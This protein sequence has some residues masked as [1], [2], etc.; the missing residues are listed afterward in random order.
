M[1]LFKSAPKSLCVLRLS[2]IGDVCHAI[3]VVQAIQKHWPK[4]E[5]TWICGKIEAQLIGDL[6]DIRVI[7]FDKKQGLK[8]MKAVWKQLSSTQ[9][10]VLLHMQAALRASALSFGIK[11]K[12]KVGFSKNRTKEGQ[13]LFTNKHLPESESFHVLDNFADFAR[14]IGVPFYQPSWNIP[15]SDKDR[16]FAKDTVGN[17]ATLVISAA[18]SK[19]SRNWLTERYALLS[20]Y[21][22]E[23]G[24]QV[25]LCGSPAEREIMLAEDIIN[26]TKGSVTNLVGKTS[27]KQ[28]TAVLSEA[29]VV[30]APD[31][32]PAHLATTQGTPVIGLYAHSDPR[33]TGPYN[34]LDLVANAYDEHIQNQTGK[35]LKDIPWG[36]RAK[37]DDLMASIS[38]EQVC[39]LLNNAVEKN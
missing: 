24:M 14:Y 22:I 32:G 37:G 9:F 33:R 5:I 11:A 12:Y 25:I 20:D 13:W 39:L 7:V 31:S 1:T 16:Q 34:S 19:D 18:A 6:P 15:V 3:S 17:K 26:L 2:A 36:T 4:T 27:L 35:A 21:A 8:G 30:L 38:V 23:Q 28:L 29:T 10:D